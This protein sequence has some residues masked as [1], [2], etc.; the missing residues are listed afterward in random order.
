MKPG[1]GRATRAVINHLSKETDM[2]QEAWQSIPLTS[3]EDFKRAAEA[4]LGDRTEIRYS[5]LLYADWNKVFEH[6]K[7]ESAE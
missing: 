4:Y 5:S 6:F 2:W 7:K 3:V 1:D